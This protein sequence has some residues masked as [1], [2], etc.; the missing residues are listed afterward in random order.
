MVSFHNVKGFL[1]RPVVK[2]NVDWIHNYSAFR[3]V[4]PCPPHHPDPPMDIF[5]WAWLTDTRLPRANGS[6]HSG[7][8]SVTVNHASTAE[9]DV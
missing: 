6:Y 9:R 7:V 4:S 8:L 2:R 3:S 5:L 1:D